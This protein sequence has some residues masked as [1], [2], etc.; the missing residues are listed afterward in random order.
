M[1]HRIRE[2]I[3]GSGVLVI[4][5]PLTFMQIFFLNT[6]CIFITLE[7]ISV[8]WEKKNRRELIQPASSNESI[9]R[10]M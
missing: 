7:C 3:N 10:S 5:F 4:R 6:K 8:T 1:L 9:A 2:P